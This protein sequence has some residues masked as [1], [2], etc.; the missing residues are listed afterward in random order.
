MKAF[1]AITLSILLFSCVQQPDNIPSLEAP[2][3]VLDTIEGVAAGTLLR[4]ELASNFIP[5]RPIDIW[6][7]SS[8]DG[9]QKHNVLYMY[10]AQMLFDATT[11]WNG[12]EWRVDEILDSLI[13]DDVIAP[14]IV[15]ALYNGGQRRN[16][17]YFPEKP[18]AQLQA[19]FS[20][21]VLSEISKRYG[22]DSTFSVNSDNYLRYMLEEVKPFIDDQ[23]QVQTSAASTAIMGSS[24]GG[25]MSMYAI[26]EYPNIFGSALCMS[27][28]WPGGFAPNEEIPAVFNAYVKQNI[29]P[30]RVGKIYFDYGTE[31]LDAMYEPFQNKVNLVLEENGF[32]LGE[33][34]TTEKFPGAAHDEK[35]WAARLH[36]PLIFAFG[37]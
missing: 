28:H 35:S 1:V 20:D 10:D 16:F 8:Y 17:E 7:P 18:A 37:K 6:L 23:F 31:T 27:T 30:E 2:S 34:W 5:A 26:G 22:S 15:V 19:A 33:N 12:Q 4:G 13:T 36:I 21:S 11:T 3:V 14:T 29:T 9:T 25:L 24:M 32:V